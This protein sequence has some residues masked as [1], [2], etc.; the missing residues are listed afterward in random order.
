MADA[1][2]FISEQLLEMSTVFYV[3]KCIN[4]RKMNKMSW[5]LSIFLFFES[6][7]FQRAFHHLIFLHLLLCCRLSE[8][9]DINDHYK[10][11]R[12]FWLKNKS[13]VEIMGGRGRKSGISCVWK[14]VTAKDMILEE[15]IEK[16]QLNGF[17]QL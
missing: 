12:L 16:R 10:L 4:I 9:Q 3:F 14:E 7:D 6:P 2:K 8:S 1:R 11:N 17:V 5:K 13:K 15:K